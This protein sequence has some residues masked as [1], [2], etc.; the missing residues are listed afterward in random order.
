[1]QMY[2]EASI[3][4]LLLCLR[5]LYEASVIT[6]AFVSNSFSPKIA[7]INSKR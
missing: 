7:T 4:Q 2:E 6:G 1:M 3:V 5:A